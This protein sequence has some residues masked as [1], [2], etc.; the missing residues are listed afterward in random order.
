MPSFL[1]CFLATFVSFLEGHAN[2]FPIIRIQLKVVGLFIFFVES[3]EF[4]DLSVPI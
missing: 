4:G 2:V 1:S 3:A